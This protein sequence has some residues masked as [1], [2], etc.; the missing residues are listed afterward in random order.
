MKKYKTLFNL[1]LGEDSLVAPARIVDARGNIPRYLMNSR[2]FELMKK[3]IPIFTIYFYFN[4]A[5]IKL[6]FSVL[7]TFIVTLF[8]PFTIKCISIPIF[9]LSYFIVYPKILQ[10]LQVHLAIRLMKIAYYVYK[11]V[12]EHSSQFETWHD[13]DLFIR[14]IHFFVYTEQTIFDSLTETNKFFP[15]GKLH[16]RYTN[17]LIKGIVNS[18]YSSILRYLREKTKEEIYVNVFTKEQVESAEIESKILGVYA[19]I[20]HR[21]VIDRVKYEAYKQR[22]MW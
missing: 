4:T 21:K 12:S 20:P 2:L 11:Y 8:V 17:S 5:P 19:V 6:L 22:F 3:Y 15:D 7:I 16:Q 1:P 10:G 9:I 14:H 18:S 13:I